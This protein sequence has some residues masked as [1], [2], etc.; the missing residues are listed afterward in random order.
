MWS[1]L[2]GPNSELR[3]PDYNYPEETVRRDGVPRGE[4]SGDVKIL[5]ERLGYDVNYR[6][7]TPAG[8]QSNQKERLPVVYVLDGQEYAA[9]HLGS[10]TI[11]L[12]NLLASGS[13]RPLMAVFIDPR[14]P[15]DGTNR[16]M[17][18]Y[19][20][21]EKFTSF[22]ADEL[23]PKIDA[24]YPT[25]ATAEGRTILGTSL[26][27]LA[28]ASIGA[29]RPEVFGNVAIQSPASFERFAPHTLVR[30]ASDKFARKP[31]VVVTAGTIGDGDAGPK[32]A[33]TLAERG[34]DCTFI[35]V[36]QGHSWGAWRG[37]L[38]DILIKLV[39]PPPADQSSPPV[40][41]AP[42]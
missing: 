30:Y 3:M 28:S 13:L 35:E 14:H 34:F 18:E 31:K 15:A 41:H 36:N 4:L 10:M 21:N 12:D 9:E 16:R 17:A 33:A 22:V 23:V 19:G 6:V 1:G 27:G 20:E 39:G 8:F 37:L 11:V 40:A 24:A 42:Q 25:I 29:T 32:L 7:Y 5:S 26:G 38:D 2:G